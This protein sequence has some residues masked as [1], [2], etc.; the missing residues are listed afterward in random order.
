MALCTMNHSDTVSLSRRKG[1]SAQRGLNAHIPGFR[2]TSNPLRFKVVFHFDCMFI[3][4][5]ME[6]GCLK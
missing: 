5:L 4:D 3:L 6:T 1:I 2:S